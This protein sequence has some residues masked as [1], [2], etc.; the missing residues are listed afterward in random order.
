ML[1]RF[2]FQNMSN[3][4]TRHETFNFCFF[5][6]LVCLERFDVNSLSK[7]KFQRLLILIFFLMNRNNF[8]SHISFVRCFFVF[9]TEWLIGSEQAM[10]YFEGRLNF[11][12]KQNPRCHEIRNYFKEQFT[13]FINGRSYIQSYIL[14]HNNQSFNPKTKQSRW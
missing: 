14:M 11:Q 2:Q 13:F 6:C 5:N 1:Q 4:R 8:L 10:F 7:I 9:W 12:C 3:S